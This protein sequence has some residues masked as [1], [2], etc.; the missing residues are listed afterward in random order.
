MAETFC[1]GTGQGGLSS[2]CIINLFYRDLVSG[3]SAMECGIVIA[4]TLNVF[5]YADDLLLSSLIVT[6]LQKLIDYMQMTILRHMVC[7]STKVK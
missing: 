3:Q 5:C 4:H 2:P 1:K 6:G 7:V